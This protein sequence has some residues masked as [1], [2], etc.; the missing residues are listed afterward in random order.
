MH[1]AR[2]SQRS[3]GWAWAAMFLVAC[4]STR[5]SGE[6]PRDANPTCAS[7]PTRDL[8]GTYS[9]A[10]KLVSWSSLEL[11]E[12]GTYEEITGNCTARPD[13]TYG[14]WEVGDG[15]VLLHPA[16]RDLALGGFDRNYVVVADPDR[17]LALVDPEAFGP[18]GSVGLT[19]TGWMKRDDPT[20]YWAE[21]LAT[22]RD[23]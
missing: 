21:V 18:L 7:K 1:G 2:T 11:F 4:T 15:E 19:T 9:S 8:A 10:I 6:S 17:P 5:G 3:K 20:K 14:T 13:R 23:K 22:L 12:G 16:T